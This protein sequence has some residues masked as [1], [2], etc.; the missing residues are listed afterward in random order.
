MVQS[1][2]NSGIHE[3]SWVKLS[4][5]ESSWVKLSQAGMVFLLG[6][7][8]IEHAGHAVF[9]WPKNWFHL[10]PEAA[11]LGPSNLEAIYLCNSLLC[12]YILIV[13]NIHMEHMTK[14]DKVII[15]NGWSRAPPKCSPFAVTVAPNWGL[16]CYRFQWCIQLG[17]DASCDGAWCGDRWQHAI[18]GWL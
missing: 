2:G 10:A 9:S 11:H 15:L 3:S 16:P 5:A 8:Q 18:I 4:Q 6:R 13:Y 7:R 17:V 14:Y 1:L 12:I